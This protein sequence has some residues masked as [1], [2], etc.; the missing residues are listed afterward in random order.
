[1]ATGP[2]L[3]PGPGWEGKRME[4]LV[5]L[6]L[7][8]GAPEGRRSQVQRYWLRILSA[9]EAEIEQETLI[10]GL[11]PSC[12]AAFRDELVNLYP[13]EP[14]ARKLQRGRPTAQRLLPAARR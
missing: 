6:R 11:E 14:R 10:V 12:V 3:A 1:M 7:G 13:D 5:K 8:P 2:H 9:L 4:P